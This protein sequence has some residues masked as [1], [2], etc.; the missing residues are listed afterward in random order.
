M[1]AQD[2]EEQ[3]GR[4]NRHG[5]DTNGEKRASDRR[6]KGNADDNASSDDHDDGAWQSA[7]AKAPALL[8]SWVLPGVVALVCG[9]AG[10]AAYW[11]FF[12]SD[13]SKDQK[14]QSKIA[15]LEKE[16]D[17]ANG[18]L[19]QAEAGWK[20]AMEELRQAQAAARTAQR[21][22]KDTRTILDFFRNTLLSAGRSGDASLTAVFWSDNL[23]KDLTLRNAVDVT[24]SQVAEAFMDRPLAEAAV[25]EMLGFA[26]LNLKDAPPAVKQY[27][28]ALALRE[29]TQGV[30]DS[31]TA[32]CRNE[33][34]IAYRLAG[35]VADAAHLFDRTGDSPTHASALAIRGEMLLVEKNAV[36]AELKLRAALTLRQ[37]IQSNDWTTFDSMSLIGQALLD[38]RKFAEAEPLLVSG[39]E[40]MKQRQ[41]AIPPQNR[42]RLITALERLVHLYEAWDKSDK[43]MPWR[44]ELKSLSAGT[45][46]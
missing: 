16:D 21:A 24:A 35:R 5:A 12:M 22:E 37:K 9:V 17:A 33:L 40:G 15:D 28:R 26:Y 39:Y 38:Q 44:I 46:N 36:E 7:K 42:V 11:H 20:T 2:V 13:K 14:A 29:A 41:K 4:K 32:N 18:K 10:A 34:A 3:T 25:R 45:K 1:A 43:A 19:H 31:D 30:N 6:V 8:R 23:G 27:E